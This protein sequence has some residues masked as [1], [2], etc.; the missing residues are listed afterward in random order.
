MTTYYQC[1]RC[2]KKFKDSRDERF[3]CPFCHSAVL[4]YDGLPPLNV[5]QRPLLI[6]HGTHLYHFRKEIGDD[7]GLAQSRA[8]LAHLLYQ[9]DAEN[10]LIHNWHY[11]KRLICKWFSDYKK[12]EENDTFE[13]AFRQG[14]MTIRYGKRG[15]TDTLPMQAMPV[16]SDGTRGP[17]KEWPFK[18]GIGMYYV[19]QRTIPTNFLGESHKVELGQYDMSASFLGDSHKVDLGLYDMSASLLNSTKKISEQTFK[20]SPES[21]TKFVFMQL[22]DPRD[23]QVFQKLNDW[24]KR[25]RDRNKELH[26][27]VRI[28]RA[29]MTRIKFAREKDIGTNFGAYDPGNKEDPKFK[30]GPGGTLKNEFGL[31]VKIKPTDITTMKDNALNFKRILTESKNVNEIVIAYRQHAG[32]FPIFAEFSKAENCFEVFRFISEQGLIEKTGVVVTDVGGLGRSSG[33]GSGQS[34]GGGS[35]Q[36]SGGGVN[37]QIRPSL[38]LRVG[39]VVRVEYH[40][41]YDVVGTIT[42]VEDKSGTVYIS[43]RVQ[44]C[45]V[46]GTKTEIRNEHTPVVLDQIVTWT[47]DQIAKNED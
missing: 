47:E 42:K 5:S 35:G 37:F 34:S 8:E 10:M 18:L 25:L 44:H 22:S 19:L 36:N 31:P 20:N 2:Q 43:I 15:L 14:R 38:N 9:L 23:Q 6:I 46:P 41:H 24:G 21:G 4:P 40:L 26:D 29:K 1:I 28:I 12:W 17:S 7:P 30:Y 32:I 39:S 16:G 45:Y 27:C 33:S 3:A 11:A 13:Q